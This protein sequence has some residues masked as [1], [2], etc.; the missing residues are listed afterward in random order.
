MTTKVDGCLCDDIDP[1]DRPCLVCGAMAAQRAEAVAI[2]AAYADPKT[3]E[4]MKAL[5]ER[6]GGEFIPGK[7]HMAPYEDSIRYPSGRTKS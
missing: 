5:A 2:E 3:R 7:D 4:E 1:S 6:T